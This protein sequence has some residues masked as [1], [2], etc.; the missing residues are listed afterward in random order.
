MIHQVWNRII[1][2]KLLGAD[3]NEI[4]REKTSRLKFKKKKKQQNIKWTNIKRR[5]CRS[6]NDIMTKENMAEIKKLK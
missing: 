4:E 2:Q 5:E 1:A 3:D 6:R